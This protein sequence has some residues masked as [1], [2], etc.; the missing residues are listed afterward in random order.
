MNLLTNLCSGSRSLCL[1]LK[2]F[3]GFVE[4]H[5]ALEMPE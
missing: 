5:E 3:D 1:Q 4:F 2:W